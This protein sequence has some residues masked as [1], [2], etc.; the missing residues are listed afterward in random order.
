MVNVIHGKAKNRQRD[1]EIQQ[2]RKL[3]SQQAALSALVPCQAHS[4][5]VC[6]VAYQHR[7]GRDQIRSASEMVQVNMTISPVTL[8]DIRSWS[9]LLHHCSMEPLRTSA[10][11]CI[12]CNHVVI[13]G[14]S[15][16]ARLQC[17][18]QEIAVAGKSAFSPKMNNKGLWSVRE[19]NYPLY[20]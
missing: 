4:Q 19:M 18:Q 6:E 17:C 16:L 3:A 20:R 5:P 13:W 15:G 10:I 12:Q 8:H 9:K 11:A 14:N 1:P 7:Y 2:E